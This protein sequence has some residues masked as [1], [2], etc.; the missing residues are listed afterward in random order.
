M[1]DGDGSSVDDGLVDRDSSLIERDGSFVDSEIC[2]VFCRD[3]GGGLMLSDDDDSGLVSSEDDGDGRFVPVS[4]ILLQVLPLWHCV[5]HGS[6][7]RCQEHCLL[8]QPL[9]QLHNVP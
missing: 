3:G 9:L 5:E 4:C 2:L 8:R 6:P 7:A 1:V